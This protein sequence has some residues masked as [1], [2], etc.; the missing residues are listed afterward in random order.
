V[1]KPATARTEK[2]SRSLSSLASSVGIARHRIDG[3]EVVELRD[4][5]S[6]AAEICTAVDGL[7]VNERAGLK[8]PLM[9][10]IDELDKL[11]T[12]LKTQHSQLAESLRAHSTHDQ[13]TR[14]YCKAPIGPKRD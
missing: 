5:D 13:A 4:L 11:S 8:P 7:P 6:A 14:A 12:S 3:G 9:A 10:L 2:I 1:G